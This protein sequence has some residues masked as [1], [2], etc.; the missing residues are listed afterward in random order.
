MTSTVLANCAKKPEGGARKATRLP[1]SAAP[2]SPRPRISARHGVLPGGSQG[3]Q[4]LRRSHRHARRCSGRDAPDRRG[5]GHGQQAPRDQPSRQRGI[6][7][8]R[9]VP[10]TRGARPGRR[11][12]HC[13]P[14]LPSPPVP[15]ATPWR[16]L[17]P[18]S[19]RNKAVPPE[20]E[21]VLRA[22]LTGRDSANDDQ[23]RLGLA[24]ILLSRGERAQAPGPLEDAIAQV[25]KVLAH[26]DPAS[27]TA[28]PGADQAGSAQ[29]PGNRVSE[30]RR[31]TRA[32]PG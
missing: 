31:T 30:T 29:V 16:S 15:G 19:S 4:P 5:R 11:W 13:G 24:W 8:A 20:A 27:A 1:S 7:P 14:P 10:L 18:T 32:E 6:L 28:E 26:L 23:L 22:R 2:R 3:A 9:T 17:W 12:R 25:N 21:R